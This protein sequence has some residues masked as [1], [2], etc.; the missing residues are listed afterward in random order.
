[1]KKNIVSLVLVTIILFV[2]GSIVSL[3]VNIFIAPMTLFFTFVCIAPAF[4][5]AA[6]HGY[7]MVKDAMN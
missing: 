5:Y 1:M 3:A 7:A 2:L 4:A 6:V